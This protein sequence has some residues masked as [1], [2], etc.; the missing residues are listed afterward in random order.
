MLP[1]PPMTLGADDL[2]GTDPHD[3]AKKV[4]SAHDFTYD[5]TGLP[6]Y[7]D[8]TQAVSSALSYDVPDKVDAY[9]SACGIVTGSSFDD[10]VAW[11]RNELRAAGRTPT[12][13]T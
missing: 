5:R 1:A 10:V 7:P 3:T 9:S 6:R 13:A 11:Y 2:S 8:A 4:L 12:S